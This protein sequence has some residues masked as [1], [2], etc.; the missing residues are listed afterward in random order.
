[1]LHRRRAGVVLGRLG[2]KAIRGRE[3][4]TAERAMTLGPSTIR[5]S[6]RLHDVVER[7][8]RQKLTGLPVTTSDGRLGLLRREDAE[9]AWIC[10]SRNLDERGYVKLS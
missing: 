8:E 4:V 6:A 3:D 5:P 7:M 10:S 1:L 9:R 2:R